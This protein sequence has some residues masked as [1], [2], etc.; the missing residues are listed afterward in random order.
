[1]QKIYTEKVRLGSRTHC[2]C[3]GSRT[4]CGRCSLES[5]IERT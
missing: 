1:M 2:S 5:Y 4:S 3:L